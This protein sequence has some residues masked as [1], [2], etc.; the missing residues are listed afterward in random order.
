L[1]TI[2]FPNQRIAGKI[3]KMLKEKQTVFILVGAGHFAGKGN[4]LELLRDR[5]CTTIQLKRLGKTGRIKP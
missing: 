1:S 2:Y 3:Y 4:I 5:G